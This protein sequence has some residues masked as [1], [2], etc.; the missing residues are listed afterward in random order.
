[1]LSVALHT[2][3]SRWPAF[4]G[5]LIA[6]TL[7][8]A[9]SGA[10]NLVLAATFH[11]PV[12]RTVQRYAHAP[13]VVRPRAADRQDGVSARLISDV[14]AVA[15]VIP[16]RDFYVY[17]TGG[18]PSRT[19]RPW[20]MAGIGGH[21]LVAGHAPRT[22][23][24]IVV[25]D[26]GVRPGARVTVLTATRERSYL[27]AG[28]T[29]PAGSDHAVF[30]TD[31]EAA[32]LSPRVDALAVDGSPAAV[33]AAVGDRAEVLDGADRGRA[34]AG[35]DGARDT[36]GDT[37]I[38]LGIAAGVAGFVAIFIV[39]STF[40]FAVARRRRELALLRMVGATPRQVRRMLLGEALLVGLIASVA[41]CVL[42]P[43]GARLLAHWLVSHGLA[44]AGF[45]VT[46]SRWPLVIAFGTGMLVALFG[47][48]AASRRAGRV[49]ALEALR[50]AVVDRNV[51]TGG[52]WVFGLAALGAGLATMIDQVVS[53]PA[54]A[55]NR[56]GYTPT[57]M[58]L[59]A[60]VALLAPLV[61][62]PFARLLT[63]PLGRMRGA[64]GMV[65]RAGAL[66]AVRSTAATAAPVLV[67]VGMA[68]SLLGATATVDADKTAELRHRVG[69]DYLVLP[70]GG[71]QLSRV[72]ADRVRAV[73]GVDV[74]ASV[75]ITVSVRRDGGASRSVPAQAVD[76]A[77]LTRM[78]HYEIVSGSLADLRDDSMVVDQDL[79]ARLGDR[80]TVRLAGG[81]T[82]RLRIAAVLRSG[83]DGTGAFLTG[84]YAGNTGPQRLDVRLRPGA[85][86]AAVT[87]ALRAATRGLGADV[88]TAR[89]WVEAANRGHG[90]NTRLGMLVVLG[91]ALVY[92]GIAI[93]NT[94]AMVTMDRARD[95]A[96]LRL[97][98][99]TPR[100][101]LGVVAGES[102]LAVVVGAV[103]ALGVAVLTLAG[104]WAALRRLSGEALITVPWSPV[105]GITLACALIALVSA[106][107]PAWIGSRARAIDVVGPRE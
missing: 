62:P 88:V 51:M 63:W 15:R 43:P 93:A 70:T 99:A 100:Q 5:T 68:A 37:Q 53:D 10:M 33:R 91:I 69:A 66:T 75:P 20:S 55:G 36:L 28:V 80:V 32:A 13:I 81:A 92:C 18:G 83:I 60:G 14:S 97:S 34:E 84:R 77:E 19:G 61:V 42:A 56:K 57:I 7:G 98:G 107:V 90:R 21:R 103:L 17:L 38:L 47:V 79:E 35:A 94:L 85:D 44:P 45:A 23:G 67:T 49:H 65:V 11:A 40:A 102:V 106:L 48:W 4:A 22:A 89:A 54:A 41:G 1:M 46:T 30:F 87:T 95:Q 16:D 58:L 59:I 105:L 82:A 26:G 6:L 86:R 52:R 76:P 50:E 71:D 29:A 101:V 74:A 39:A 104:Q 73:G 12:A 3:R 96:L 2:L 78:S 8:V 24:E 25:G 64:C 27:V 9:M 31:A 72:V